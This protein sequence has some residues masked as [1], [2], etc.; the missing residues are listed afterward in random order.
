MVEFV[1][2]VPDDT[3]PDA[4][5]YL[6]GDA[7]VLG[8]WRPDAVRLDPWGDGTRRARVAL[9]RG[10]PV[11]YHVTGGRWRAVEGNA[12]GREIPPRTVIHHR[13]LTVSVTVAGWGRGAVRYHP[14]FESK[15]LPHAR[16]LAVALPPGY[17]LHPDRRY[18][19]FYLHDGQNL[20]DDATAFG[21]TAWGCDETADRLARTGEIE[22]VI[23]VGVGNSPARLDEYGPKRTGRKRGPDVARE[24][25][26]F[27]VGGV[28]PFIDAAYRTLP[29][30]RHTAVGGS[31]MGGLISLY[32]CR[33]HPDV[34]G[35][36]AAMSPS[37]WWDREYYLRS[38]A[39]HPPRGVKLWLDMGGREGGTPA[40][41][42]ANVRR[43][44]RLAAALDGLGCDYRYEEFPDAGHNEAA[45]GGRFDRVLR[46]LFGRRG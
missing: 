46:H 38:V 27:L 36:C 18:P 10:T 34:F 29:D 11:R 2:R 32:L 9:P 6:S 45:W 24:Y 33:W 20:F 21:G 31:S 40:G 4:P 13:L 15:L 41:M 12:A 17:D 23:L 19:A 42:R 39:D 44:A 3:P 43:A 7:D 25:A 26:R 5:V 22:P 8:R 28:K 30:R 37:L 16:P 35:A 1:V 14:D